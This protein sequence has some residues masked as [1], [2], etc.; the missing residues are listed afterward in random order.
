MT[1]V[2]DRSPGARYRY[3]VYGLTIDSDIP[4]ALPHEGVG[5]LGRVELCAGAA[6]LFETATLAAR[7][8]SR[9]DDWYQYGFLPDGASYV[10]WGDVG[11][12]LVSA[13]GRRIMYR[14]FDRASFESFQVYMLGQ[15]LSFALIR[16]GFEPLH[17]TAVVVDGRAAAFLGESGYGK[18]TLA[19][20]FL[21]AGFPVLTDDVLMLRDV[22]GAIVAYPGPSRIKL[23]PKA[24]AAF[25]GDIP[26]GVPMNTGAKKRILSLETR[27][28]YGRPVALGAIYAIVPPTEARGYRDVRIETMTG[29]ASALAL[30]Q[31]TFN[32][33]VV[34][35]ARL[36]RQFSA[37]TM[38]AERL[39]VKRLSYPRVLAKLPEVV[40]AIVCDVTC[41]NEEVAACAV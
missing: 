13:A 32:R 31:G 1:G 37:S 11:E 19:A 10:R 3:C 6:T 30:I 8:E 12:F 25:L 18:S 24:A 22:A 34:N 20:C 28:G 23:F 33:K 38:L 2:A 27:H 41:A 5:E 36:A 39:P 35:A 15:A 14:R 17:A 40:A 7:F 4:L 9:P 26:P 16:M 29:R 21:E